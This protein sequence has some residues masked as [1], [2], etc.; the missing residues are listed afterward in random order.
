MNPAWETCIC[1]H[2]IVPE[3]AIV[4]FSNTYEEHIEKLE[5]IFERLRQ[6]G[7][8]LKPSKCCFFQHRIKYLGHVI[9][10]EGVATDPDKIT[11]VK[12]WPVPTTA[13]ELQSFIGF[14]GFYRRFIKHF[15]KIPRPL[16]EA[17]QRSGI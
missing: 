12:A 6:N 14:V 11:A 8:K 4:V 17:L 3:H 10:D 9:L 5:A 1:L 7:L 15:S 16:H 2:A 13:E